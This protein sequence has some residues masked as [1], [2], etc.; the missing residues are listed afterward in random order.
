MTKK[1][2][3]PGEYIPTQG[4]SEIQG[5]VFI[6][7]KPGRGESFVK[8]IIPHDQKQNGFNK[9]RVRADGKV[10]VP[11][12]KNIDP[13]S[14]GEPHVAHNVKTDVFSGPCTTITYTYQLFHPG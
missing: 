14:L 12:P 11:L 4:K 6:G 8:I 7:R 2:I 5:W 13:R 10:E 1:L 3:I 9:F